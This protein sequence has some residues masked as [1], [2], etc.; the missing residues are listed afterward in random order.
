M[1]QTVLKRKLDSE[2]R[3]RIFKEKIAADQKALDGINL[4]KWDLVHKRVATLQPGAT[5]GELALLEKGG[6]R[7]ATVIA[8]SQTYLGV[9]DEA[10]F[11]RFI[12]KT[13][14]Q[15]V[16][17][18]IDFVGS[19]PYFSALSKGAISKIVSSLNT[20]HMVKG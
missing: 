17:G 5:F 15:R 16:D 8:D 4:T 20:T 3:M 18:L 11:T 6:K 1:I 10:D 13:E 19:I 12:R 9:L 2:L 7:A 14:K